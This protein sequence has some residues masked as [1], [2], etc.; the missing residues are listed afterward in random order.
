MDVSVRELKNHLSEY[1]RRVQAGE[2]LTVTLRG[3]PVARFTAVATGDE[4]DAMA[5]LKQAPGVVW[6]QENHRAPLSRVQTNG[7]CLSNA[8]IEERGEAEW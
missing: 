1:L 6:P 8:V 7:A 5:R 4:M 2:E 3:R